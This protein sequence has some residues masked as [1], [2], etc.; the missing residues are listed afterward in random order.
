MGRNERINYFVYY[1]VVPT[2]YR[3]NRLARSGTYKLEATYIHPGHSRPV[4]RFQQS[5]YQEIQY[6]LSRGPRPTERIAA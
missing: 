6:R 5:L 3:L 4:Y 2:E 1:L